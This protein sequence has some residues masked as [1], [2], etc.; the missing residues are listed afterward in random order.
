MPA[1]AVGLMPHLLMAASFDCTKATTAQEKAICADPELS[2]LDDSMS[3][4][5]RA[6]MAW[7]PPA[8]KPFLREAQ[9]EWLRG[10][11]VA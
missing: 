1:I 11:R 10:L 9:R 5:Y 2:R 4:D 6:A 8:G 3:A 7:L